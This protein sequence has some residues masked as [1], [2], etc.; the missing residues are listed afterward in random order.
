MTLMIPGRSVQLEAILREP[1]NQ[2]PRASAVLCHPHPVYGGTMDNRVVYRA[3]KAVR[4]AGL[5]ALRFNFRGVGASTG[6]FDQGEGEKDD[7]VAAIDHLA[8]KYP[9]LPVVLVGFS[10][11]AR[12]G[13]EVGCRDTR[14]EAMVGLGLPLGLHD[15]DYLAENPKPTVYI[16][17][18]LDQYCPRE[19]MD[20]L[21][22]RF[23][24]TSRLIWIEEADHFFNPGI[25]QVQALITE[26][27]RGLR[28]SR[29]S[30]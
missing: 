16:V 23:P 7:V 4:E 20:S 22:R 19:K 8:E 12:V 3:A 1:E 17:G 2:S 25:E 15:F 27:F 21:A 14:I 6:S 9:S 30:E 29:N 24:P 10:F 18:A 5:A 11:G 26:F 13:L 28:F